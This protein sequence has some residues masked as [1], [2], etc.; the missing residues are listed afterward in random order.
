MSMNPMFT[1][2][3]FDV[4]GTVLDRVNSVTSLCACAAFA[5]HSSECGSGR[6]TLQYNLDYP[7]LDYPN[8][9]SQYH[10]DYEILF[11]R[12]CENIVR[13]NEI[14]CSDNSNNVF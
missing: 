4:I 14:L 12:V 13:I 6:K 8:S 3:N 7:N 10:F 9:V 2:N 5:K 11:N 1:Q